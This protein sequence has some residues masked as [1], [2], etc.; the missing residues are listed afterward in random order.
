MNLGLAMAV[1]YILSD[2]LEQ[3]MAEAIYDKFEDQTFVGKI[4]ICQGVI[5]FGSTLKQCQQE[6]RST[7]EDW[8][9]LGIKLGHPLPIINNIDLNQEPQLEPMETL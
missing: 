2:Y 8:T 7:L 9:L 1:Q 3:A 4:P 6:L 5:A